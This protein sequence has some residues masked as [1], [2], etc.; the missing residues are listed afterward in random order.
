VSRNWAEPQNLY[1]AVESNIRYGMSSEFV[2]DC[3]SIEAAIKNRIDEM[4]SSELLEAISFALEEK[5]LF[6]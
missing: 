1:Q 3:I 6:G 5:K 4:T 2:E